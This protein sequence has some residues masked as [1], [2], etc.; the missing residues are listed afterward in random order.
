MLIKV[1]YTIILHSNT[2]SAVYVCECEFN[3]RVAFNFFGS[4]GEQFDSA[5]C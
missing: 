5:S 4:M 3:I 1:S 2:K